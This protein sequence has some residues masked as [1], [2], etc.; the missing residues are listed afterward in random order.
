MFKKGLPDRERFTLRFNGSTLD[1]EKTFGDQGI[2]YSA[3]L[4]LARES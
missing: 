1:N 3:N 4:D 2:Y